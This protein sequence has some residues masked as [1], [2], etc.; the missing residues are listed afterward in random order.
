[1]F[2]G[3]RYVVAELTDRQRQIVSMYCSGWTWVEIAADLG[4]SP[5]TINPTLKAVSRRL[6]GDGRFNRAYLSEL[7][8]G[9]LDHYPKEDS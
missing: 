4:I 3:W 7:G 2:T 5:G 1:L 6:G 8:S 9:Q